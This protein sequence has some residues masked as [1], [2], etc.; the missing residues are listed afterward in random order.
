[1]KGGSI[2][3][4]L[5]TDWRKRQQALKIPLSSMT[6]LE[7]KL[8]D[9]WEQAPQSF[10]NSLEQGNR[11]CGNATRCFRLL[12]SL[13]EKETIMVHIDHLSPSPPS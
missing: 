12:I 3:E 11:S 5:Q 6:G 1:M 10:R 9:L 7:K 4:T 8:Q 13:S 2:H